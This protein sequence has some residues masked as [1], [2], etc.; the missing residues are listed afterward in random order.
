M[1]LPWSV[2]PFCGSSR[3]R[4]RSRTVRNTNFWQNGIFLIIYCEK[5]VRP[6]C[7]KFSGIVLHTVGYNCAN[8]YAQQRPL[9][10]CLKRDSKIAIFANHRIFIYWAPA[11][12]FLT[13]WKSVPL[14]LS[15]RRAGTPGSFA[16]SGGQPLPF[17]PGLLTSALRADALIWRPRNVT[18]S[19]S[20]CQRPDTHG[21]M[22][23][24]FHIFIYPT[25][26]HRRQDD[27]GWKFFQLLWFPSS[28][29]A[30]N[31]IFSELVLRL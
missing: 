21:Q 9:S 11:N 8:F 7:I 19:A 13:T 26:L 3:R 18:A 31:Y 14:R 5:P 2:F 4:R 27:M 24:F 29:L 12:S 30:C 1:V 23:I 10:T 25:R 28:S 16:V 6:I 22:K 15:A 20:A 17:V